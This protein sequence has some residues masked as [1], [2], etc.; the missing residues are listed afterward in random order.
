M[1]SVVT[2]CNLQGDYLLLVIGVLSC[3]SS[4]YGDLQFAHLGTLG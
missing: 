1:A 3:S 4:G 2:D